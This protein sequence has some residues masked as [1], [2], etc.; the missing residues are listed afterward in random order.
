MREPAPVTIVVPCHDEQAVLPSLLVRLAKLREN[1]GRGWEVLFVDDGSHDD[2]FAAL[3]ECARHEPWVRVVRH[4]TNL[5]VGA[6]LRTALIYTT[7]PVVCTIDCDCTYPPEHL[8]EL[9]RLLDDGAEIA[10]ASMWHP[11]SGFDDTEGMR[12]KLSQ[13]VSGLYRRITGIDV[14]TF[15]SLCRAYRRDALERIAFRSDGFGAVAEI[16]VRGIL[17]GY[18]VQELPMRPDARHYG[19][20]KRKVLN[21]IAAHATMLVMTASV[22]TGRRLRAVVHGETTARRD[23]P[24]AVPPVQESPA[25]GPLAWSQLGRR[26]VFAA[27]V[28][29]G[30]LAS[31]LYFRWWAVY[32]PAYGMS[33]LPFGAVSVVYVVVQLY[34]AW[35]L[36]LC[37]KQPTPAP[38][39]DALTVDVFVPV[40]DEPLDLVERSLAGALAIRYPHRTYLLDDRN[41][42]ALEALAHRLGARYLT[43]RGNENAKAGNI[44]AA[45]SETDGQFVTVFDVDHVPDPGFLDPVLG[46]F[47]DPSVGFVQC[48]VGFANA[49]E[50][51]VAH[52]MADQAFDVYGPTSMGMYG[53]GA[54]PVWGSHCTFRR[55]ALESIGGHQTGLAEDLHTSLRL[56]AA[57]WRSIFVPGWRAKGLAPGDLSAFVKQQFKWARGVFEVLLEVYPRLY[58][59]L[60]LR[61]NLAYLVRLTYYLVGPIF[62]LHALFTVATLYSATPVHTADFARYLLCTFPL[63]V[64]VVVVRHLASTFWPPTSEVTRLRWRGY[65]MA[66]ALWPVTTLALLFALLRIPVPHIPTPKA[67][68]RSRHLGLVVPQLVLSG[69]LLAGVALHPPQQWI[70]SEGL[71][72][73]CALVL[74]TIQGTA[75]YAAL[76]P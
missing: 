50:S 51:L 10:T 21:R 12:L 17:L 9:V 36:Y 56:H 25:H 34:F 30:V 6:A 58:G 37:I 19:E 18:R 2:T 65:V 73:A 13:L 3:L 66:C 47:A 46:H 74:S 15:T 48:G 59:C 29:L 33:M 62:L 4:P 22:V 71:V 26:S 32:G 45:L 41:D 20:S 60:T 63:G 27:A 11:S 7:S 67:R 68:S 53:C 35:Y 14:H 52:A 61:Q 28:A 72:A 54:A 76:R 24:D 5:G 69:A 64:A 70:G 44:N 1:G 49:D 75:V 8:P 23:R 43:R 55:A 16:M 39:P 31:A 40:Y 57:R 38:A 42:P